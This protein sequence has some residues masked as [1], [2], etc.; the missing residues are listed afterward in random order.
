MKDLFTLDIKNTNITVDG[1]S[2]SIASLPD[3]T[4][5]V[6]IWGT[7]YTWAKCREIID[8]FV[9]GFSQNLTVASFAEQIRNC[10]EFMFYAEKALKE[11]LDKK[12]EFAKEYAN[13]KKNIMVD[14][15]AGA[16]DKEFAEQA[17]GM[18]KYAELTNYYNTVK[19][20]MFQQAKKDKK[21]L[22]VTN[23]ATKMPVMETLP[24]TQVSNTVLMQ[25]ANN[26]QMQLI[27]QWKE[28][29]FKKYNVV[30]SD[31]GIKT[32]SKAIKEDVDNYMKEQEK[33]GAFMIFRKE[34]EEP[35]WRYFT[36]DKMHTFYSGPDGEKLMKTPWWLMDKP[37]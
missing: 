10:K 19:M 31:E 28:G 23:K 2:Y 25:L 37:L 13:N 6:E 7:P 22:V 14:F 17:K 16:M 29:V 5:I 26:S 34:Y 8:L 36:D 24:F 15:C 32:L 11:G 20:T 35:F 3:D 9:P 30:V 12:P 18:I 4:K 27:N 21:G 33:K 1:K